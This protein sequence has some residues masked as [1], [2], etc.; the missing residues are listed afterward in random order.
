MLT[1]ITKYSIRIKKNIHYKLKISME[2]VLLKTMKRGTLFS[3]TAC[4]A[5]IRLKGKFSATAQRELLKLMVARIDDAKKVMASYA[6]ENNLSEE[7]YAELVKLSY[8]GSSD[9]D[10]ILSA[11]AKKYK[12]S[13]KTEDDLAKYVVRDLRIAAIRR[14]TMLWEL[15]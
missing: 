13:R 11:H 1:Q 10:E 12:N 9:A 8:A 7:V 15:P 4:M 14:Y 2:K 5:Y 6:Q 3:R